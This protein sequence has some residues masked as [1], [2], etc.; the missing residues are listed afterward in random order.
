MMIYEI[1]GCQG[2]TSSLVE[3]TILLSVDNVQANINS[4][5]TYVM[6]LMKKNG[7]S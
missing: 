5:V 6:G 3:D 7:C 2:Q 1:K 4:Y